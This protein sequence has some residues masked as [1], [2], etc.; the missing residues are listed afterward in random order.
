MTRTVS[1]RGYPEAVLAADSITL[2][3]SRDATAGA[4]IQDLTAQFP[5]LRTAL[6]GEDGAPRQAIRVLADGV[7]ISHEAPVP[8][9]GTLTVL[10]T[11]PCDG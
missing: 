10:A 5:Q 9:A 6:L 4:V 8:A 11:L 3:S 1:L 7:P 2:T